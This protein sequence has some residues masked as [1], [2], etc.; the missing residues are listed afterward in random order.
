MQDLSGDIGRAV[1]AASDIHC[2]AITRRASSLRKQVD[3]DEAVR[4]RFDLF[5]YRVPAISVAATVRNEAIP[6][7][8]IQRIWQDAQVRTIRGRFE[9]FHV[10]N[11]SGGCFAT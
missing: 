4:T 11:Q 3:F 7:L 1:V 10:E 6:S 9:A 8:Q 5:C 2:T